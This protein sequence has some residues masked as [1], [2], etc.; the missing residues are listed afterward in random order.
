MDALVYAALKSF[1]SQFAYEKMFRPKDIYSEG[2]FPAIATIAK[3]AGLS[4][5]T[6]VTS[7]KRLEAANFIT[8]TRFGK[9]RIANHYWFPDLDNCFTIPFK[10]FMAE[11]LTA[12]E[13]AMLICIR[14]FYIG[15]ELACMFTEV[16]SQIARHLGLSY[17]TVY[18]QYISLVEK[19]YVIDKVELYK[20][21]YQKRTIQLSDKLNWIFLAEPEIDYSTFVLE[22]K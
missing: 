18:T 10:L 1:N 14:Q 3:Q 17:K 22:L 16:I 6:V 20:K 8:V 13:K 19:G 21:D 11:D 9:K 15:V 7:L 12:S 5:G 4:K 2:C